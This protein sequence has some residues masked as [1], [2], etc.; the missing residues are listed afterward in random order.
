MPLLLLLQK[1]IASVGKRSGGSVFSVQYIVS[2]S[3]QIRVIG[4]EGLR[5]T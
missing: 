3:E 1:V 4:G 5:F 2:I